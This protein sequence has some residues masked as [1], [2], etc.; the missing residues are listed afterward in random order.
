MKTILKLK[1]VFVDVVVF[2]LLSQI[3]AKQPAALW[4]I[5][6]LALCLQ[7]TAPTY[8]FSFIQKLTRLEGG[9]NVAVTWSLLGVSDLVTSNW[10]DFFFFKH[11]LCYFVTTG[12]FVINHQ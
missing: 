7:P 11:T 1:S 3:S 12:T 6:H 8:S 4:K 9:R 5:A 10:A 2:V